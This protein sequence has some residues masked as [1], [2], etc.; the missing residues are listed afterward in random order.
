MDVIISYVSVFSN[1][2]ED[3]YSVLQLEYTT[4]MLLSLVSSFLFTS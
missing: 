3:V 2:F 4:L 1:I